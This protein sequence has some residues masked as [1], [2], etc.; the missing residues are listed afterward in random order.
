[1]VKIVGW[2]YK[3][4]SGGPEVGSFRFSSEVNKDATAASVTEVLKELA[5]YAA[6]GMS[7]EE[8]T[9]MRSAIGQRDALQYET[10]G[11]KLGLLDNVL[12]YDLPLDYRSQQKTILQETDRSTLNELA[13]RLIQPDR[14]A[15][16]VVGDAA[17]IRPELEALG[18]PIAEM[19]EDGY[20][21]ES[22]T[23]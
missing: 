12:D 22:G 16:V 13:G 11:R 5:S 10:P 4:F 19:D 17:E 1:M 9:Y 8:F 7:E 14:M 3:N 15:I 20:L 2:F 18:I 21:V 23:P 6:D